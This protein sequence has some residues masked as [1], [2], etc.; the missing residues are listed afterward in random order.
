MF[1]EP[2]V[3]NADDADPL[4]DSFLDELL[5][6]KKPPDLMQSILHRL[7]QEQKASPESVT[8]ENR[9]FSN[10]SSLP[11]VWLQEAPASRRQVAPK[12][13]R[14]S[15]FWLSLGTAAAALVL[16]VTSL[17]Q[18][19]GPRQDTIAAQPLPIQPDSQEEI[20][21]GSAASSVLLEPSV[22]T[23]TNQPQVLPS[24]SHITN[25]ET[26]L[27]RA[28]DTPRIGKNP[29]ESPSLD[30]LAIDEIPHVG[31]TPIPNRDILQV[32]DSQFAEL[33]KNNDV[34][35]PSALDHAAWLER[36]TTSVL[37]RMPTERE[38]AEAAAGHRSTTGCSLPRLWS[39]PT[40]SRNVGGTGC[41]NN[42][43][44][45]P[46]CRSLGDSFKSGSKA[47]CIKAFPS[48]L[49]KPSYSKPPAREIDLQLEFHRPPS[50]SRKWQRVAMK[51][52]QSSF[53][54]G[55]WNKP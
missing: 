31:S 11:R 35:M 43:Y 26:D 30:L 42:G 13:L 36:V 7:D 16:L 37:D 23:A 41:R 4:M 18:A 20:P 12:S 3:M 8:P 49:S 33:W 46:Q 22:P 9:S 10:A 47:R 24:P 53:A 17:Q 21:E 19:Q 15:M 54:E 1:G 52:L 6:D 27:E 34:E 55:C 14:P 40:S 2:V 39:R 48:M 44:L 51:N 45:R 28:G 38:L 29:Q 50:G 32:I 25:V 5:G